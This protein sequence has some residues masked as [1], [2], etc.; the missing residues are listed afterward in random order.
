V[1]TDL[2]VAVL[3]SGAMGSLY[4][5]RLARSGVDVTLVDVWDE[6]VEA[7]RE[8]GLRIEVG[9]A[10][11]TDDWGA[12]HGPV[13]VDVPATTDPGSVGDV[14]LV[15]VFVKSTAT[16]EA[17]ADADEAGLLDG[18]DVLTLQNGLGNP[19][20]VAEFVPEERVIAGVTSHGA[21]LEGPGRVF[22]AGAGPTRIGRYFAANDDR[23][24][25]V[26]AAFR[27]SGFETEVTGA[28]ADAIWEKVLVNVGINAA[29]A[30]ARVDNGAL[31]ATAP[32]RRLVEAAVR[33][34]VAVARAEGHDVRD[35][36]VEHV[37]AV[38]EATAVNR[39]SMRQDVEAGRETEI[40]RLHGAVVERAEAAGIDVP[41]TRT[42]ADL[43][44]LA[45]WDAED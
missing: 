19:E 42:L 10:A 35:N 23:V 7:I 16:V 28:V 13:S 14:D 38:A 27:E 2:H 25:T 24:E 20:T 29:T 39:S 45:D 40:E 31:A 21:T 6:H 3:G 5:G 17:M 37:I 22:H 30:L 44:R 18:A 33:E 11:A 36:A 4:G 41:V 12:A 34:A 26:A 15:V 43:V 1:T 9:D 32:G 8:D